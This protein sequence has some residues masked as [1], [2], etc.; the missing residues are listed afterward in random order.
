MEGLLR[1]LWGVLGGIF[2]S[3]PLTS[4][5][6]PLCG[7]QQTE[8]ISGQLLRS[9]LQNPR[10]FSEVPPEVRPAV[11]TA[12][13]CL[14]HRFIA[15]WSQSPLEATPPFAIP[16]YD[17]RA[18]QQTP[19]TASLARRTRSGGSPDEHLTQG[20]RHGSRVVGLDAYLHDQKLFNTMRPETITQIIRKQFFWVTDLHA[21]S[22]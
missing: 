4:Q 7:N 22:N 9:L 3:C 10:N 8:R 14:I 21:I 17:P 16:D 12:F 13:L 5:K 15:S 1:S 20:H 18:A 6:L 2:R 19:W 11:H